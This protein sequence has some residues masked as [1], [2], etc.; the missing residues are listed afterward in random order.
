MSEF[1]DSLLARR[2]A[3]QDTCRTL[4]SQLT[5]VRKN[6]TAIDTV[7]RMENSQYR[8][9]TGK[10]NRRGSAVA[11]FGR[12]QTTAIALET[13][14]RHGQP[15]SAAECARAICEEHRLADD[16]QPQL[17]ARISTVFAQKAAAG[18]IRR[19]VDADGRHVTWMAVSA[20]RQV[21]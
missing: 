19:I 10:S 8:P 4:K 7:L 21:A 17:A 11:T 2:R 5:A 3:L 12:G 16:V 20:P 6:I 15:M 18:A 1:S 14:R 9:E 13:L